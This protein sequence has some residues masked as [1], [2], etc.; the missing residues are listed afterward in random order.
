MSWPH[1]LD[2][3]EH[4]TGM[5]P[6]EAGLEGGKER[7]RSHQQRSWTKAIM[8]GPTSAIQMLS[9]GEMSTFCKPELR[10]GPISVVG[11]LTEA[12]IV[13]VLCIDRREGVLTD[14]ATEDAVHCL[15][16]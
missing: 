7:L 3:S 8:C 11:A 16:R 9:T 2:C 1:D 5:V 15:W 10:D 14:R 12:V 6:L 4:T 13:V